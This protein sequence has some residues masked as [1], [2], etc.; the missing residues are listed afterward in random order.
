M[1]SERPLL[2]TFLKLPRREVVDVLA[3]AGFDFLICDLEHAATTD[4][5]AREVLAT[6][7][8]HGL[9]VVVRVAAVERG[10]VNHLLEAGAAG[11]QVPRLRSATQVAE[12]TDL[13]R[14]PP[15]GSR[16][17]G[18][19]HPG[20]GYGRVPL[21]AYVADADRA[22]VIV[23]QF[24]TRA[25]DDA[26]DDVVAGL[27]VAFIGAVDLTVDHGAPGDL[28]DPAVAA[29]IADVEAAAKRHGVALGAFAPTL[30]HVPRF[31]ARGYRYVA[32]SGDLTFLDG[33]ATRT[34]AAA[35]EALSEVHA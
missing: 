27:D 11:I 14:F 24:E 19:A 30:D 2:G 35:R 22:P 10:Q 23:G 15:V 20:A 21:G 33:G 26:I 16:S 7:A 4:A 17:V 34:V 1:A 9:P 12:L 5:E 28:D 25:L 31:A 32:V 8:A 3:L 29:R 6:A 13:T 18:L